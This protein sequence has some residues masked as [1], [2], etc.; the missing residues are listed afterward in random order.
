MEDMAFC[1]DIVAISGQSGSSD[2]VPYEELPMGAHQ[3]QERYRAHLSRILVVTRAV[4][5][6]TAA[7]AAEATK[8]AAADVHLCDLVPEFQPDSL[9]NGTACLSCDKDRANIA[10]PRLSP[11][12]HNRLTHVLFTWNPSPLRSSKFS[13]ATA[14]KICSDGGS[15][16]AYTPHLERTPS[17]PLP[18]RLAFG[19][20]L[21]EKH[22]RD[23][24]QRCQSGEVQARRS[25]AI[26]FQ[27]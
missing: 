25:S 14:T 13:L 15:G 24:Q 17:R 20:P 21:A 16:R 8:T 3:D 22:A 27:G 4:R 10:A 2:F 7:V 6:T 26:R 11:R 5:R 9:S 18:T 19:R 12:S 23:G 1:G